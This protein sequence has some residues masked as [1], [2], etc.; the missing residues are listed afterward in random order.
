MPHLPKLKM[1]LALIAAT[2]LSPLSAQVQ[3]PLAPVKT[4][5][6]LVAG[7]VLASGVKAW[8]GIPFAKPPVQDLRWQAP[9]PLSW[10]G[11]FNADRTG[12][13]CIQVLRPHNI[14]HYFGEEASSENCLFLNVWAP[15]DAASGAKLPVVVFIYGGGGTIGSSGSALYNGEQVAR[16]GAVYVGMNYRVGILG[17]M[18]HPELTSEQGGHSGNYGYLDQNAALRWVHENIAQFGGDPDKVVI[19][20]QSA[21]AGSVTQQLFSPLSKGLFRGAVMSSGCGWATAPGTPLAQAEQVGLEVQKQLGVTTL[22]AMRLA[23]ADRILALQSEFQLGINRGGIR[24]G[25]IIDGYFAPKQQIDILKEH[26]FNDVPIIAGYNHDEASNP[27]LQA[28]TVADYKALAGKFYEKDAAAFL[29]AY[30]VKSDA[31]VAHQTREISLD[32][33]LAR[34]ARGCGLVQAQ[35]NKSATYINIFSH[36]PSFAP[37]IVYA[38]MKPAET[39]AYHTADIPFWFGTQEAFNKFRQGR[40]WT[41]YDRTL[42]AQMT[43]SLIAFANSGNPAT[44]AVKWMPWTPKSEMKI[45]FGDKVSMVPVNAKGINWLL[46][47]PVAEMQATGPG[48]IA[49]GRVAGSPRD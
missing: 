32:N 1:A 18:A 42:S 43:E 3:N 39:G 47:H 30:P 48:G 21:G 45:E 9:Q 44:A 41:D 8:L 37:G 49:P 40:A 25:P 28:K 27:F 13:E 10:D 22:A 11:V 19:M 38:D 36:K 5:Q 35:Y 26:L 24:T 7:Q 12:P 6:G 4:S 14:N 16:R 31:D 20:G 23:P 2:A 33:G 46:A 29:A 17:Y 34:N 15:K